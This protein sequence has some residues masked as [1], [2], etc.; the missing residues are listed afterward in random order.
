MTKLPRWQH[1]LVFVQLFLLGV[2]TAATPFAPG[3]PAFFGLLFF[4]GMLLAAVHTGTI[5]FF[6]MWKSRLTHLMYHTYK[7][8]GKIRILGV[9]MEEYKMPGI[10]RAM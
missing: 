2:T 6:Y 9:V 10:F 7:A 1:S 5:L 8:W 3:L 4:V